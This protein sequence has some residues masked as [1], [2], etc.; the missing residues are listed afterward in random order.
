MG[1]RKERNWIGEREKSEKG[2]RKR[3]GRKWKGGREKSGKGMRKRE[4]RKWKGGREK[5]GDRDERKTR[6]ERGKEKG[7]SG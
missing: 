6:K 3:E 5:R 1:K 4:G 7:G 2:K